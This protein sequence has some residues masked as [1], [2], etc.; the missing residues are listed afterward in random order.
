MKAQSNVPNIRGL[1]ID[2]DGVLYIDDSPIPGAIEAVKWCKNN[3]YAVRFLT[4]TSTRPRMQL[5]SKLYAM[6]FEIQEYEIFSAPYAARLYL[7]SR[8]KRK[9]K[10]I[11]EATVMSDFLML[12]DTSEE[13][14][15][16]V[17]GDIGNRWD[18]KLL[19]E[20]FNDVLNGAQIVAIHKNRFWQTSNGLQL[21]IGA[22]VAALEYATKNEAFVTGKPSVDFFALA[23]DDMGLLKNEV[24]LIGDDVDTDIGGAM[25][26]G[27]CAALCKTGKYRDDYFLRSDISPDYLM[28]SIAELPRFLQVAKN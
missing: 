23:I 14:T 15:H 5:C 22:F 26:F 19:N 24:M 25:E 3:G 21:D 13:T 28:G 17:I 4:N 16:I 11:V 8:P 10:F 2:L 27:I 7:E 1:L 6:G 9:C 12:N 18:Y 20:L